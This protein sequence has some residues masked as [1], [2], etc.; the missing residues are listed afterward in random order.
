MGSTQT[1]ASVE[2]GIQGGT[3][4]GHF[5]FRKE[6]HVCFWEQKKAQVGFFSKVG[7]LNF[8]LL[9]RTFVVSPVGFK[10]NLTL[11]EI[12]IVFPGD[13]SKWKGR[14]ELNAV[15]GLPLSMLP[16]H[17]HL[18]PGMLDHSLIGDKRI[19]STI[20]MSYWH[21]SFWEA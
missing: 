20:E 9:F 12:Y 10:G 18:W 16:L 4:K 17:W 3:I 13:L 6:K 11:L 14:V 2:A 1:K 15:L 19:L 21:T 7:K 8:H 5:G